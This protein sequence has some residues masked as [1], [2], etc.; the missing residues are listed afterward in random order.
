M[1]KMLVVAGLFLALLVPAAFAGSQRTQ[2]TVLCVELHGNPETRFD[3]K[4]RPGSKCPRGEDK[5]TL[6]RGLRG[7]RGPAGPAGPQGGQGPAG[8]KGDT[9]ATGPAGAAGVVGAT[10]AKGAT[11]ATGPA[12]PAGL[13]VPGV[14]VTHS[15]GPDS[16]HCPGDWANDDYD[17]TLQFIPQDDGKIQ[18][19]RTYDGTFTTIQGAPEPN[20]AVCPGTLQTGG[21]VGTFKGFDT[22]IV[23]GGV[24]TPNATCPNPCT[25]AAMLATFFPAGGAGGVQGTGSV[26]NGWE[27]QYRLGNDL[28][29]NRSMP[30]GGDIGNITGG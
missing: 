19:V 21:R 1:N 5:V 29:V 25:T 22:L 30:R 7:P 24:F 6:P 4:R 23:T 18:V 17:R 13:S 8:A 12:G 15:S 11:G 16:S 9:G 14:V 20:P 3:V 27:Y 2:A 26:T 10:G 28:W